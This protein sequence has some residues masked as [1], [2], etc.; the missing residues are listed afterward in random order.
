MNKQTL[1]Y[2]AARSPARAAKRPL[3]W[4]TPVK[5]GML[6]FGIGLLWGLHWAKE[7]WTPTG[8][9]AKYAEAFLAEFERTSFREFGYETAHMFQRQTQPPGP[10]TNPVREMAKPAS[11]AEPATAPIPSD[12]LVRQYQLRVDDA[13]RLRKEITDRTPKQSWKAD[14]VDPDNDAYA[15]FRVLQLLGWG[16]ILTGLYALV[17]ESKLDYLQKAIELFKTRG[18][19]KSSSAMASILMVGSVAA[20]SVYLANTDIMAPAPA[21]AAQTKAAQIAAI[22]GPQL[23]SHVIDALKVSLE[24]NS[25]TINILTASMAIVAHNLPC[26]KDAQTG[27]CAPGQVEFGEASKALLAEYRQGLRRELD[28]KADDIRQHVTLSI[29]QASDLN[30][31]Q[32]K[33]VA[34]K[35]DAAHDAAVFNSAR[36]DAQ[37]TALESKL[38]KQLDEDLKA[39]TKVAAR[40]TIMRWANLTKGKPVDFGEHKLETMAQVS[41]ANTVLDRLDAAGHDE[42]WY[43]RPYRLFVPSG[44]ADCLRL[45]MPNSPDSPSCPLADELVASN[46][47]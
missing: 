18:A 20:G 12:E 33:A 23:T 11:A 9:H 38:S 4:W 32:V 41:K 2:G 43:L 6:L 13:L 39:T 19:E 15:L 34:I 24:R 14:L 36:Q 25:E 7:S 27:T 35:V 46:T 29:K 22:S 26:A 31:S 45:A 1:R 42:K 28:E 40:L 47:Q 44:D 30:A 5:F 21:K 3:K 16:A 37:T 17:S 8:P 10:S